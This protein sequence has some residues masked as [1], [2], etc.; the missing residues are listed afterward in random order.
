MISDVSHVLYRLQLVV[1][2]PGEVCAC[3]MPE[4]LHQYW[5]QPFAASFLTSLS[6]AVVKLLQQLF[7]GALRQNTPD[8]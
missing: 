8:R 5:K 4:G 1:Q 3:C 2:R 7:L 6:L